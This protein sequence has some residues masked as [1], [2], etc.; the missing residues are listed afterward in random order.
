MLISVYIGTNFYIINKNIQLTC[1]LQLKKPREFVYFTN[2]TQLLLQQNLQ[3]LYCSMPT[4]KL[5][6]AN[7]INFHREPFTFRVIR[8][9]NTHKA[10][11]FYRDLIFHGEFYLSQ[12]L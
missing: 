4:V 2:I 12:Q 5:Y 10:E 7:V 3:L 1:L 11:I 6:K 8:S 9:G